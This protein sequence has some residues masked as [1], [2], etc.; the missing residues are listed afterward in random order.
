MKK[1]YVSVIFIFCVF[2]IV[3]VCSVTA[4]AAKSN[5]VNYDIQ[6][7]T[8][9]I[10]NDAKELNKYRKVILKYLRQET[11]RH[12]AASGD[13]SYAY[14]ALD[15]LDFTD[16]SKVMGMKYHDA[17]YDN[18]SDVSYEKFI[19][20]V[21]NG[22]DWLIVIE[23]D[24][25]LYSFG[26]V[27]TD[28]TSNRLVNEIG[29]GWYI[30]QNPTIKKINESNANDI[31]FKNFIDRGIIESNMKRLL[32]EEKEK[33]A[34]I[35]LVFT[36]IGIAWD[37]YIVFVDGKAKYIYDFYMDFPDYRKNT[38]RVV[39]DVI[40]EVEKDLWNNCKTGDPYKM[41][42]L[43]SYNEIMAIYRLIAYYSAV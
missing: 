22:Q 3:Q 42:S 6:I 29:G 31:V 24:D 17:Y 11:R 43:Y 4:Y 28:N 25:T 32:K 16:S 21:G 30:G 15:D 1:Y 19:Q 35:K 10:S 36:K 12:I 34:D 38:P 37:A 23:K 33:S 14:L 18:E 7:E 2:C 41:D 40:D 13:D 5:V 8:L 39:A 26:L 9:D 27:K 20:T